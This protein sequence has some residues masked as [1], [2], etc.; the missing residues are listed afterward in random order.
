MEKR[1]RFQK[2]PTAA[3]SQPS[4]PPNLLPS[5]CG[6]ANWLSIAAAVVSCQEVSTVSGSIQVDEKF[7]GEFFITEVLLFLYISRFHK[8]APGFKRLL[9]VSGQL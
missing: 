5:T 6:T 7:P 9:D 2:P 3:S 8:L 1:L 4:N